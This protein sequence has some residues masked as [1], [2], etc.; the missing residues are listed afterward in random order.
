LTYDQNPVS[1][2][3]RNFLGIIGRDNIMITN[4]SM[5]RPKSINTSG[6]AHLM[7]TPHYTLHGIT[8]SLTG[9]V[10]VESYAGNLQTSPPITCGAGNTTS[11][12]CI[13]QTGGVIE[14]VISATYAGSGTGLR[15]NR[16][17]DPCQKTNRRPPFFPQTGRFLDNKYYELDPVNIESPEQIR[18]LFNS[19]RGR[20]G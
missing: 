3:C 15:E 14:Q 2:I 20:S 10:G 17:V 13:N 11:G 18:V 1:S 6:A 12:G 7:G 4:N 19:L 16:T 9:T 5:N 8:M